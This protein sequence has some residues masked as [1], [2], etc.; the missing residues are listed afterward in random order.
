MIVGT[1]LAMTAFHI[2]TLIFEN[3]ERYPV[4]LEENGMPHF[5]VTLWVTSKLRSGGKAYRTIR[6]K[7]SHVKWFLGWQEKEHRDL[8][9]EFQQGNFLCDD[10]IESIKAYLALDIN[11]LNSVERKVRKGKSK[12]VRLSDD[13]PQIINIQPSVGYNHHYNRMTSVIEY[14]T[15][16]AKIAV[17]R[18][19][20]AKNNQVL[21]KMIRQFKAARPKGKNKKLKI[22]DAPDELVHDFMEVAHPENPQNPFKNKSVQLRNYLMFRLM[23][24]CGIRSGEMLSVKINNMKL[25]GEQKFLWVRRTHDDIYDSRAMQPVAKTKERMIRIS[26]ETAKLLNE[27]ITKH[28]SKVPNS[29]KH[30]YL[31]VVHKSCPSQGGPVSISN[32]N[33]TVIPM[34]RSVDSKFEI[35]HP[36]LFRHNWNESFSDKVD[37]NNEL[38]SMGVKGYEKISSGREAKMRMHQMGHTNESSGDIYNQR[39]IIRKANDVSIMDQEELQKKAAEAR[40]EFNKNGG[41]ND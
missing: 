2:D 24:E 11:Y 34:M 14:L 12:T 25:Y 8:Y 38:A 6:N 36:H 40:K 5:F 4:L 22:V 30:P 21:E 32:F 23:D 37:R 41:K 20:T 18:I 9:L 27:Y 10:D 28:R 7:I 33:N 29:K 1:M 19:A 17:S 26:D 13:N 3:G 39:H 15:F 35:I 16:I 31:F